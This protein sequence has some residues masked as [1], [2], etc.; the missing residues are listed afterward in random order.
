MIEFTVEPQTFGR[1]SGNWP[2]CTSRWQR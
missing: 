1:R 2:L